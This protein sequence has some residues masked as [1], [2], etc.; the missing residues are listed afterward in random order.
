MLLSYYHYY[1]YIYIYI[2]RRTEILQRPRKI[3]LLKKAH[4]QARPFANDWEE[5][6]VKVLWSD[7]TKIKLL[8][9]F[10]YFIYL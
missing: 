1:I 7:E 6:W 3:P 10:I 9:Y 8:F 2:Y 5:N 4:V